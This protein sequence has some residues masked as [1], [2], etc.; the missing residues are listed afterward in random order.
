MRSASMPYSKYPSSSV[1]K[2]ASVELRQ[3]KPVT[4][5]PAGGGFAS[6]GSS[7]CTTLAIKPLADPSSTRAS[8]HN[9]SLFNSPFPP[10]AGVDSLSQRNP[11]VLPDIGAPDI[12]SELMRDETGRGV[13]YGSTRSSD[14]CESSPALNH[15]ILSSQHDNSSQR[16]TGKAVFYTHSMKKKSTEPKFV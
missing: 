8:G 1:E 12:T 7:D 5:L 16:S 15:R 2:S 6:K 14:P 4:L 9:S 13:A 10:T 3:G 11:S